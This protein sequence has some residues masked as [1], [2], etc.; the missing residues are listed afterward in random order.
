M[1][2]GSARTAQNM[3]LQI[4]LIGGLYGKVSL[5]PI[6]SDVLPDNLK[7]ALVPAFLNS[8]V[9]EGRSRETQTENETVIL[10]LADAMTGEKSEYAIAKSA[11]DKTPLLK[12]LFDAVWAA[13]KPI[14]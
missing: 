9:S 11:V 12:E 3:E 5:E 1:K 13:C 2:P 7:A 8:V 6:E 14:R 4:E 10:K